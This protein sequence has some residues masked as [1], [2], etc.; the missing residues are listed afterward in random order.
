[1]NINNETDLLLG[2]DLQNDF[3]P[4]GA[5]AVEGGADAVRKS[6]EWAKVFA[7][8][9]HTQDW[10]PAGH[11]SFASSHEGKEAFDTIPVKY[12][13]QTLWPDHCV[14]GSN[15][16]DFHPEL[17]LDSSEIILR[18]GFRKSIDSYSAFYENDHLTGTGFTAY[19]RERGFRRLFLVG[20]ATDVCVKWTATDGMKEGFEMI[21]LLDGCRAISSEGKESAIAEMKDAGVKVLQGKELNPA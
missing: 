4:G 12:G 19:L 5:L 20:L 18:K 3:C 6:N 13:E 7:H 9:A 1:M 16:A 17:E 2:I 8:V 21:V 11:T 15:G 14:I 10:H